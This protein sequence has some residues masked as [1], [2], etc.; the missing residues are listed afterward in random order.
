MAKNSPDRKQ[1]FCKLVAQGLSAYQAALQAGYSETY[2]N[3]YAH[4]LLGKY[5]D[6]IE[7]LKPKVQ[8]V[9]EKKFAYDVE[10]SFKKLS[11]I[12]ELALLTDEKGNYC[13][14]AAAIRAEELKGKMYGC[15]EL[16]NKQKQAPMTINFKREYD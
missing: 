9:L 1:K 15:Y 14:L 4:K 16:D 3:T 7:E 13:N 10:Q 2:A 6:Q 8:A 5:K 11:Q 12:Q